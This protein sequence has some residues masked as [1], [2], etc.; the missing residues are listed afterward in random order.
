MEDRHSGHCINPHGSPDC[1]RNHE[2]HGPRTL[3]GNTDGT[4]STDS[5]QNGGGTQNGG[6]NEGGGTQN[7]GNTG[8]GDNGGGGSNDAPLDEG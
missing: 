8:G 2:L 7:G 1:P 4:D 6:T 5:G 3:L